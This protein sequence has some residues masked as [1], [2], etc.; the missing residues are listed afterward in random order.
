VSGSRKMIKFVVFVVVM[1]GALGSKPFADRKHPIV[2]YDLKSR[3]PL[4]PPITRIIP[5]SENA[6]FNMSSVI[7]VRLP[8]IGQPCM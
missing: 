5:D 3:E 1:V 2:F 7:N 4:E 6:S 8:F